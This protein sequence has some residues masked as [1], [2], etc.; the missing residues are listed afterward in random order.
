M[1]QRVA[2]GLFGTNPEIPEVSLFSAWLSL[3]V[4]CA[5]SVYILFRKIRA[6]EEVK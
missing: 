1:Q 6:Y 2:E 4:F 3:A 5:L